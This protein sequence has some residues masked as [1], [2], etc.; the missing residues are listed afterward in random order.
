MIVAIVL[1]VVF[2][3]LLLTLSRGDDAFAVQASLL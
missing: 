3:T 2:V 1:N